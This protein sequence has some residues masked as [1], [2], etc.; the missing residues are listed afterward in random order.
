MLQNLAKLFRPKKRVTVENARAPSNQIL[1][2]IGDIHGR[3]DLLEQLHRLIIQDAQS[4]ETDI[5][6][7]V[8]YLGDYIDRGFQSREVIDFLL[9]S[10][11]PE[12]ETHFLKGNHEEQL[13]DFLDDSR[14]GEGW[15]RFGGDATLFSYGVQIP[16]GLDSEEKL[17]ILQNAIKNA[18]PSTHLDFL[19]NL[20]LSCSFGDYMFVHAGV[21]PFEPINDQNAADLLWIRDDF[22]ECDSNFGKVIIHGHTVRDDPEIRKNRIGIDTGAYVSNKLTCLVLEDSE[23]RFLFT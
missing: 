22:L 5:K 11:L 19:S 12:Y 21:N 8:I 17:L 20:I 23:Y 7:T 15:L 6:K 2:V 9:G 3:L 1:Y 16:S 18:L 14:A 13:L 10:P 4:L